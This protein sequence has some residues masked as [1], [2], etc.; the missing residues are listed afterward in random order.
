M[1]TKVRDT[2]VGVFTDFTHAEQAIEE[3]RNS[4]F[5]SDQVGFIAEDPTKMEAPPVES[6]TQAGKDAAVGA[7]VGGVIGAALGLGVAAVVL[8]VAGPVIVGGLL[9]G[10]LGGAFTGGASGGILGA[11][12]GLNVP[13]E[14]ARHCEQQ[15]HSGRSLVTV[16]AG[17]RYD[18]AVA[19]LSR[20]AAQPEHHHTRHRT[21]ELASDSIP[22]DGAGS[23]F[24]PWP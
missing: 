12:I 5:T 23:V 4:G 21:Y 6:G 16:Q 19:I 11:L 20:V 7:T 14:E 1:A 15:F 18:E 8:P 24:V 22:G 17:D 13:E 10:A 3:L 9:A 2:L